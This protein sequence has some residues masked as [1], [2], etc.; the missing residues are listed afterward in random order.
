[1]TTQTCNVCNQTKSTTEFYFRKDNNSYRLDCKTCFK[2][3]KALRESKPGVKDERAHKERLRRAIHSKRI[4]TALYEQRTSY[5]KQNVKESQANSI[6]NRKLSIST[7]V[8]KAEVLQWRTEQ[9]DICT[10]CGV[11]T[12]LT[13]D[14]IVPLS[15]NGTH[16]FDNLTIACRS[17]NTSK[18]THSLVYW[19]ATKRQLTEALDKKP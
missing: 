17:C 1:M 13:I 19:F 2:A 7:G 6:A 3:A 11:T 9:P 18:Y 15:K 14:H 4:N 12:N 8:S 16:T 5:L 10:Y